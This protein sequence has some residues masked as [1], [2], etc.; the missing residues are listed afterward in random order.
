MLGSTFYNEKL[1]RKQELR[2]SKAA[3]SDLFNDTSK[4]K[5]SSA[6]ASSTDAGETK[7]FFS[8]MFPETDERERPWRFSKFIIQVAITPRA[9]TKF[10]FKC[11]AFQGGSTSFSCKIYF[12]E[13]FDMLRKSCGCDEIFISSLAR[14]TTWD[15]AGGKSGSIFLK[16]KGKYTTTI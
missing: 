7:T 10:V 8:Q 3:S 13:Q 16:T 4:E 1:Q 6:A 11:I 15:T 14:C 5:A 12:A 2:M 9:F